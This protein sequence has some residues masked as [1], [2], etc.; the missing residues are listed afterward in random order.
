MLSFIIITLLT[1][2]GGYVC[3]WYTRSVMLLKK[4]YEYEW[5]AMGKEE[6]VPPDLQDWKTAFRKA[7]KEVE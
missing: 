2:S 7:L 6:I 4:M 3:G 5:E 1:F